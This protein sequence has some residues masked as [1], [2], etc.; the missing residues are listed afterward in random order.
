MN[1]SLSKRGNL[2]YDRFDL[3]VESIKFGEHNV[4]ATNQIGNDGKSIGGRRI[5]RCGFEVLI[6]ASKIGLRRRF[7]VLWCDS[8]GLWKLGRPCG[9]SIESEFES[10]FWKKIDCGGLG[11]D[12]LTEKR[13]E[14]G[15]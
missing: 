3:I 2:Q 1:V 5:A 8:A 6:H 15:V 11:L 7:L 13:V 4:L 9:L 10:N 14:F 12:S